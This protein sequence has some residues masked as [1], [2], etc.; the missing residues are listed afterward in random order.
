MAAIPMNKSR[1]PQDPWL[2]IKDG[3]WTWRVL[4]AYSLDPN[5]P[6]AR[7]LCDVT[8]PYTGGMSDIGDTYISDI[9]GRIVQR[10]PEVPDSAIPSHLMVPA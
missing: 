1:T 7:W 6:G 4:R 2:T 8:S 5:K 3:D 10:D 9:E